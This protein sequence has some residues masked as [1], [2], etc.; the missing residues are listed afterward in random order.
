MD[1]PYESGRVSIIGNEIHIFD[2]DI[3]TIPILLNIENESTPYYIYVL[4]C[5]GKNVVSG[6]E[7]IDERICGKKTL[8]VL[9]TTSYKKLRSM[10]KILD[11]AKIDLLHEKTIC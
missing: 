11:Y 5:K 3:K 1:T 2:L 9:H 6:R 7:Y 4:L 10:E 8:A